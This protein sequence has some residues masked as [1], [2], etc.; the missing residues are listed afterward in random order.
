MI[1]SR[2]VN[3]YVRKAAP[4]NEDLNIIGRGLDRLPFSNLGRDAVGDRFIGH[5]GG[6]LV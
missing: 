5:D 6:S 2:T 4:D 1:G 3:G